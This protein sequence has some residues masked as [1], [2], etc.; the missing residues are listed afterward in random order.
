VT[1]AGGIDL[2]GLRVL[3][4]EDMLLIADLITEELQD[5]GCD[6]VGPAP[7]VERGLTLANTE[8]LDGALLDVNLAGERCFPIAEALTARGIP[9]AFLTGFGDSV[10]PPAYQ[11]APRLA[12]PFDLGELVSLVDRCFRKTR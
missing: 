9:F 3:V 6:V 5:K 8:R 1:S 2:H 11:H 12:K 4:V 7:R 10:L